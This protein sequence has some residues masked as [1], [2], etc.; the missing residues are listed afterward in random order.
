MNGLQLNQLFTYHLII[1]EGEDEKD[2]SNMLYQIQLLE[3]FNLKNLDV[4][5]DKLNEKM[6]T[7]YLQLKDETLIL[8]LLDVHPYK[9]SMTHELMFRTLFS[10]DYLYLFHKYLYN[11][12]NKQIINSDS[13]FYI[14]L[15]NKLMS[16]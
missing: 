10:Y 13:D 11:Y 16:K 2:I 1:E 7:I 5:F 15:K 4:D 14:E 9:D 8:E 3:L 6:D 12:F